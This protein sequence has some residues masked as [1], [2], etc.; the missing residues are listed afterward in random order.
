MV[1]KHP[2]MFRITDSRDCMIKTYFYPDAPALRI[3]FTYT[4]VE[5]HLEAV[6]FTE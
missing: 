1:A 4:A 3:V 6:K 2:E 5:V